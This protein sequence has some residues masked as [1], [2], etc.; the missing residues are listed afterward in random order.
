MFEERKGVVCFLLWTVFLFQ[1]VGS[2][3]VSVSQ[4]HQSFEVKT[5]LLQKRLQK[6]TDVF[7]KVLFS[8]FLMCTNT[9]ILLRLSNCAA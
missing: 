2:F 7:A 9:V 1:H 3:Q 8:S 5:K 6:K 4:G